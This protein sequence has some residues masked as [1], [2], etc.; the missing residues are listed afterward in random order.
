MIVMRTV[1]R[2]GYA[3]KLTVL[4]WTLVAGPAL[5]VAG[6][7]EHPCDCPNGFNCPHESD[8]ES[9][10][11]SMVV[12]RED[13][14][15]TPSESPELCGIAADDLRPSALLIDLCAADR[16]PESRGSPPPSA[17]PKTIVLLI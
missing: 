1:M 4:L 2:R 11:C 13:D 9:D 10:P 8:C 14:T 17:L 6:A 15:S 3:T 5:C 16:P 12:L 7:L